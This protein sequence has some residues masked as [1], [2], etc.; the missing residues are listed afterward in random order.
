MPQPLSAQER[1]RWNIVGKMMAG[2]VSRTLTEPA[3]V[4][5]PSNGLPVGTDFPSGPLEETALALPETFSEEEPVSVV[6]VAPAPSL[7]PA[8]EMG[9][10]LEETFSDEEES[11]EPA[12]VSVSREPLPFPVRHLPEPFPETTM[13]PPPLVSGL[14]PVTKARETEINKAKIGTFFRGVSWTGGPVPVPVPVPVSVVLPQPQ[15]PT[16]EPPAVEPKMVLPGQSAK[17]FFSTAIPWKGRST[18][19]ETRPAA[20]TDPQPSLAD[21]ISAATGQ[22]L[23]TAQKLARRTAITP[24][25]IQGT[26]GSFFQNL[27][28]KGKPNL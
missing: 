13:M 26:A 22:A 10:E 28:W 18:A 8:A 7:P 9:L 23:A 1:M 15:P 4:L 16:V 19:G 2:L 27:S 24:T 20:A 5:V 12:V 21:M 14:A 17:A 3:P 6:S 25:D 11:G